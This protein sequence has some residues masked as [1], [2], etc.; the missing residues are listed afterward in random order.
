M[1]AQI[2]ARQRLANKDI[3]QTG[4][5]KPQQDISNAMMTYRFS[6]ILHS[7]FLGCDKIKQFAIFILFNAAECVHNSR[8]RLHFKIKRPAPSITT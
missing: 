3:A 2:F 1:E 7:K 5:V 4:T 8:L 6:S